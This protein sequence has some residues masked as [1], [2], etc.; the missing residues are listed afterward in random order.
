MHVISKA[1]CKLKLN[2]DKQSAVK[3]YTMTVREVIKFIFLLI[4][5]P[6]TLVYVSCCAIIK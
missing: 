1:A 5:Q 3:A 4:N 6:T 2:Y